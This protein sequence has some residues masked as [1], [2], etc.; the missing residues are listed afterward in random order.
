KTA[1]LSSRM[2]VTGSSTQHWG[3]LA[4]RARWR[5]SWRLFRGLWSTGFL[6]IL[7][8]RQ[9]WPALTASASSSGPHVERTNTGVWLMN[10]V[11]GIRNA[12]RAAAVGLAV[13]ASAVSAHA[14][15]PTPGA[16]AAAKEVVN[17]TG[18][19]TVFAPLVAGVIEQS[20]V[21]FLQQ[22]PALAKDLDEVATK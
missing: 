19:A 8:R 2:A 16:L 21:L 5:I 4:I 11:V 7:R 9:F 15:Q 18:T 12:T 22:N 14:Q 10:L 17:T 6:S 1:L 13:I 20:K 3:V